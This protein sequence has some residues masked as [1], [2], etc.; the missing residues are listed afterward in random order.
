MCHVCVIC[1]YIG[2][3]WYFIGNTAISAVQRYNFFLLKSGSISKPLCIPTCLYVSIC[4]FVVCLSVCLCVSISVLSN[5]SMQFNYSRLI[6]FDFCFHSLLA[7]L[8]LESS[9]VC[10]LSCV[11][12]LVPFCLSLTQR[13]TLTYFLL[14]GLGKRRSMFSL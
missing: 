8:P 10:K 4:L 1:L 11:L 2:T 7:S 9:Q 6:V 14:T 3:N 13:P 5:T 12:F